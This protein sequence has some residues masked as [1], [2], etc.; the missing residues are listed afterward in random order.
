MGVELKTRLRHQW[1]ATS[2]IAKR[3]AI[4]FT[5]EP[6]LAE[7]RETEAVYT[8]AMEYLVAD[9]VKEGEARQSVCWRRLKRL[10]Q[11]FPDR[12][13]NPR[14]LFLRFR[15][16]NEARK[17]LSCSGTTSGRCSATNNLSE[18]I[19]FNESWHQ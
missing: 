9:G 15:R 4:T 11:A 8:R 12:Y 5:H 7:L 16:I 2:D 3:W 6:S 10:H 18:V 14:A 13:G 1:M 17:R 19:E